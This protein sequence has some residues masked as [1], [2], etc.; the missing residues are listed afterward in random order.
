MSE[1]ANQILERYGK[2]YVTDTQLLRYLALEAITQD[3]YDI[4]YATKHTAE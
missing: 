1:K 2:G 3:E 4:I